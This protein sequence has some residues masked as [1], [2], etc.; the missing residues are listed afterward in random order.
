MNNAEYADKSSLKSGAEQIV[1]DFA[2]RVRAVNN[3]QLG[4]LTIRVK[5]TPSLIYI[6][7]EHQ[8]IVVP[9]WPELDP[10]AQ[11]IFVTLA[12]DTVRGQRLFNL[13]C[14]Q[15]I[16]AHEAGHWLQFSAGSMTSEG[17]LD[18]YNN[19]LEANQ[20]AVAYWMT[21]PRGDAHLTEIANLLEPILA[22]MPDPVPPESE[23]QAYFNNHYTE[24]MENPMAYGWFQFRFVLDALAQRDQLEFP[25]VVKSVY[26]TIPNAG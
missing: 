22:R 4:A 24:L 10:D 5:N 14:N 23:P 13:L 12:G 1:N 19:E 21:T 26:A 9:W 15:F 3:A 17:T 2:A 7:F 11:G 8:E 18:R 6:S 25:A 20:I 16:I